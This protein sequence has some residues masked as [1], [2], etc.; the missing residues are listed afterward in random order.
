MER[1]AAS[2]HANF[3]NALAG[4]LGGAERLVVD[5]ALGLQQRGH[6]VEIHTSHHDPSHCF[7]ETR[8]GTSLFSV[9]FS[10]HIDEAIIGTLQVVYWR[11]PFFLPRHIA[12]KFHILFAHLRQLH[13]TY[14]LIKSFS[15]SGS[16]VSSVPDIF[17]MD[18]LSTA[19]PFLRF[20]TGRRV[21]FYCHFPDKLL[22]DGEFV[23]DQAINKRPVSL[24]KRIYRLPMNLLEEYTTGSADLILANSI[25][26]ARIF[27]Q[28]LPSIRL[29]KDGFTT[30]SGRRLAKEGEEDEPRIVYPGINLKE[31]SSSVIEDAEDLRALKNDRPTF[32]SLNRFEA[33]KNIPLAISSF[34][35][36]LQNI[37]SSQ[38]SLK[39]ARLVL[40]GGFDPRLQDNIR[41]LSSIFALIEDLRLTWSLL[42]SIPL[43]CV[44]QP[45]SSLQSP[46]QTAQLILLLNFSTAQR[47]YL[48]TSPSTLALL[49][50]PTN[51][52]FGI[53]PIEGMSAGLPVL[54]CNSGGPTE[55]II[56]DT[57]AIGEFFGNSDWS[58]VDLPSEKM[59]AIGEDTRTGWLRPPNP[60]AWAQALLSISSLSLSS[61]EALS[62][63]AKTRALLFSMDSMSQALE[64]AL[65]EA[66]SLGPVDS[67]KEWRNSM[68]KWLLGGR[69]FVLIAFGAWIVLGLWPLF[70]VVG[71]V[72][73]IVGSFSLG[74]WARLV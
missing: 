43:P 34:H 6:Q 1:N 68:R 24:L 46:P 66:Y 21:V 3:M 18:Q 60:D 4:W 31:Y 67:Q 42:S 35:V 70:G 8:D 57:S 32:I 40:G 13:L 26:T 12:G 14:N 47:T 69:R 30:Q 71:S 73:L 38:H 55:S 44:I 37:S 56:D 16:G 20:L 23:E 65:L 10:N 17:F 54:A 28:H 72:G 9:T 62:R 5:A 58:V 50:T 22:A 2:G 25:F 49:Y 36:F 74:W 27:K 41:T 51:E 11:P 63:R 59:P 33:K 53:V 48:L 15:N 61:R 29:D 45:P 7:D 19:I 52:H 64:K 39:N